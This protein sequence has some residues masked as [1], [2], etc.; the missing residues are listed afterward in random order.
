MDGDIVETKIQHV[1]SISIGNKTLDR[2]QG[3][4]YCQPNFDSLKNKE[5]EAVKNN[6]N[7]NISYSSLPCKKRKYIS[8]VET[9]YAMPSSNDL[10][11]Q[12]DILMLNSGAQYNQR[13]QSGKHFYTDDSIRKSEQSET[14]QYALPGKIKRVEENKTKVEAR[15]NNIKPYPIGIE[16]CQDAT[17]PNQKPNVYNHSD[18]VQQSAHQQLPSIINLSLPKDNDQKEENVHQVDGQFLSPMSSAKIHTDNIIG[19]K[20]STPPYNDTSS[21]SIMKLPSPFSLDPTTGGMIQYSSSKS[22]LK[23]RRALAISS[24]AFSTI[25]I[26]TFCVLYWNYSEALHRRMTHVGD[27]PILDHWGKVS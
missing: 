5:T 13:G 6:S 11:T 2:E 20:E 16:I 9:H 10:N 14:N 25:M 23:Y 12:N 7:V 22:C 17:V 3:N 24:L 8:D 27:E 1:E 26:M 4:N 15:C 21:S 19:S 18:N